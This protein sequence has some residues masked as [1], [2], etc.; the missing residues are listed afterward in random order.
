M[1]PA[2]HKIRRAASRGAAMAALASLF[3]LASQY[4]LADSLDA[5][6]L[7]D[8]LLQQIAEALDVHEIDVSSNLNARDVVS[9]RIRRARLG[10][11]PDLPVDTFPGSEEINAWEAGYAEG[12]VG[13]LVLIA[14][15][16]G[17]TDFTQRWF[18][19]ERRLFITFYSE[20]FAAAQK[21]AEV[22]AANGHVAELHFA[23]GD[24]AA[25]GQYYATAA[26]R[27]AID[28]RAA[29]RYRTDVTELSYLGERVRRRSNS[30]FRDD[31]NRGDSS[32][33]RRE[34]SVFLKETLGDEFN[35]STISEIVVPGGVALGETAEIDFT[36]EEMR[37]ERGSLVLLDAQDARLNLPAIAPAEAKA[38]FD[39]VHRSEAIASDAIVDIDAD[40]RV[41]IA[42]T[43]RD[44]D[45]GYAIMHADT[46]PFEFVPNL[47][48]TKSVV[49]DTQVEWHGDT[50][51]LQFETEFEVRFLSADNMRIAQTRAALVYEFNSQAETVK[52]SDSW[53]RDV[54]RLDENMD[55]AGLGESMAELARYAGWAALFRRLAQEDVRFLRGRYEFMKIDKTGQKTPIRY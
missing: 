15:E 41:R 21:V 34:P 36:A 44:T 48:V 31:G 53:G 14:G 11:F 32:L 49:I 23:G 7:D 55:Y 5:G 39:F 27:L 13:G 29:R 2:A 17:G 9:Q 37:Y 50:A 25:A 47:P 16:S 52:Y 3:A 35:Q 33:A 28:S 38:L 30:L 18:D 12:E 43:L 8:A 1:M 42:S 40:G 20:D 19:S 10:R 45:A 26:Q 24:S 22:A 4:T 54:R 46:L 6:V 51:P